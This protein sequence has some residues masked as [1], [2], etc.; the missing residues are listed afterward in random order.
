M[1]EA[2]RLAEHYSKRRYVY[3]DIDQSLQEDSASF[4]GAVE[5]WKISN[6]TH[7][8][9]NSTNRQ[10]AAL[11]VPRHLESNPLGSSLVYCLESKVNGTLIPLWLVGSFF[12]FVPARI[13][14]S[15]ALDDAVS[16][17][18][19]IYSSPYSFHASIY[20]GYAKALSSLRGCLSDD[21]QRMNSETL[22][23]SILLQM[24]E[25]VVS[26]DR[27]QWSNLAYGTTVL[28][29]SRGVHQYTSAFDHSMLESQ[30]SV[31]FSQSLKSKE[32]CFL[33]LPE[34]QSLILQSPIWPFQNVQ[35]RALGLRSRLLAILVNSPS[36]VLDFLRIQ[37][38]Q[39]RQTQW[40][41]QSG[42]LMHKV[43][44]I[45]NDLKKWITAEAEPLLA[46]SGEG[47]I[48]SLDSTSHGPLDLMDSA[49]G[50]KGCVIL[51]HEG[52]EY[53]DIIAG[54][55]DC[56][57]H[58]ALITMSKIFRFLYHVRLRSSSLAGQSGQL[59]LEQCQLPENQKT[60][61]RYRQR[62]TKAFEFVQGK[63]AIAA[64]PLDFGLR[65]V[66]SRDF[67][68]MVD[69][70]DNQGYSGSRRSGNR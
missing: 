67:S 12:Q 10:G 51:P 25:L 61:E 26:A 33:R 36:L 28:L 20:K 47:R 52:I 35:A 1:D 63:S 68:E 41:D 8:S 32:H 69:V 27:G 43:S 24:C 38:N 17:L 40:D 11:E 4:D 46:P 58:T 50:R 65:Q 19:G 6:S 23:A 57:A 30:L 55:L 21:S 31:I 64:K 39:I 13:G 42:S 60:I 22:C 2:P 70:L 53:P 9:T 45:S 16:C 66:L 5:V 59:P 15:V 37:E 62:A 44:R 49:P 54:V 29:R 14:R 3:D 34:W 56:V 48:P 18:C 7:V